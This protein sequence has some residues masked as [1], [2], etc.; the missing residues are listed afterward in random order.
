M[1]SQST[2]EWTEAT[3][4]PVTGCTEVSP[5]CDHC[6]A[7]VFAER[8]RG[9]QGHHYEQG[10]ELRLWPE[11][12]TLPLQWRRPRRIFTNSMSD[13]FHQDVPTQFILKVFETMVKADWHTYQIL[14]KRPMRLAKLVPIISR[15]LAELGVDGDRWP[16]HIWLGVSIETLRYRWRADQ[17]R[18]VPASIRFISA[19]PLL[20]SLSGLDLSGIQWLIAGGESGLEHRYCDPLWIREL[21]D[22]CQ[23]AGIAFFFKQWG[24]RTHAAGG[25]NLDSRTWDEYPQVT[26]EDALAAVA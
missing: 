24:G 13:L 8:W 16:P 12:L 18:T 14:T 19:E 25:R 2:I 10:F 11:R 9:V 3:W 22:K 26:S 23:A 6:Y 4:N 21:R 5:G 17:L 20:E 15:H 1:A 7:K